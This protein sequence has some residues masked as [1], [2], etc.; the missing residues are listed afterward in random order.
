MEREIEGTWE[1]ILS[2][3]DELAGHRV[4]VIVLDEPPSGQ[5]QEFSPDIV[6]D[7]IGSFDSRQHSHPPR[8][9]TAFEEI[10]SEKMA[11]QGIRVP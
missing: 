8:E 2:H 4:K 10:L 7:L 5:Q 11:K 1:E 6:A 3:A 9:K